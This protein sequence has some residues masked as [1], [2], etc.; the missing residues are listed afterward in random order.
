MT[1]RLLAAG[2]ASSALVSLTAPAQAYPVDCAI[3]L[4]LAGGWPASAECTQARNVFIA[5][6]TPWPVEPPLQIWNCPMHAGLHHE[7]PVARLFDIAFRPELR[8]ET[9]LPQASFPVPT[10]IADQAD[11]DIS[12]PAYDFVRSIRVYQTEYRRRRNREGDCKVWSS[13]RLGTYGVQADY[14][15]HRSS[16]DRLPA[17]SSFSP[18][19]GCTDYA[20]RS[21]FVDWQD[22]QGS[23]GFEEVRY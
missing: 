5:R 9:A 13:V 10:L 23:Y 21:V 6:I 7:M 12:D 17:A 19:P 2:L 8:P 22:F 20:F 18:T 15:W 1:L 11:I 4:C 3:L 14:A 16:T